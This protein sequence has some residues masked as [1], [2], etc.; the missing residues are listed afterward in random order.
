MQNKRVKDGLLTKRVGLIVMVS[1]GRLEG[2]RARFGR[3]VGRE[4]RA[5]LEVKRK[6]GGERAECEDERSKGSR[7][8][9]SDL[10]LNYPL[11][12]QMRL[13]LRNGGRV[14]NSVFCLWGSVFS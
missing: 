11:P 9:V 10:A 8:G 13:G 12:C 6:E 1:G 3:G 4:S 7:K 5:T 14:S 2:T